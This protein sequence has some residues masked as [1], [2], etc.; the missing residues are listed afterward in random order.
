M[1]EEAGI[2][3]GSGHLVVEEPFWWVVQ[4][5]WIGL[6]MSGHRV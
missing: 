1:W 6:G 5:R 4:E 3:T 2:G